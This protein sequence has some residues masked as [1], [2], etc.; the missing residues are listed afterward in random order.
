MALQFY[1]AHDDAM[2]IAETL[3]LLGILA[4]EAKE[5]EE[6]R[7]L[8]EEALA[9]RPAEDHHGRGRSLH[10]LA[11]LA[12]RRDDLAT[13]RRL[14]EESLAERRAAGDTRGAAETSGNLGA[15][16]YKQGDVAEA[17]RLYAESLSHDRALGDRQGI[18]LMLHNLGEIAEQD[19]DTD[20]AV[21][22]FVHAERIFRDLQSPFAAAPA[23]AL[24]RLAA[25]MGAD[26]FAAARHA[27]EQTDVDAIPFATT[28]EH[29]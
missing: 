15:I 24:D 4:T 11:W 9:L 1:R 14:Y 20:R 13:A 7:A 12:S 16:A 17:R 22:L 2:G 27:A 10:N 23:E 29:R 3:T 25:A 18:A 26:T 6:A 21:L 28:D 8:I 19:G 5:W